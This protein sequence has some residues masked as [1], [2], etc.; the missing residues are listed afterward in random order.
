MEF[1]QGSTLSDVLSQGPMKLDSILDFAIQIAQA[2]EKAH[3]QNIV[4]RDIKP[5]NIMITGE[6]TVKVV[7]FGLAHI[8][9]QLDSQ[10]N[11]TAATID[12][13]FTESGQIVGTVHFL[14]PEQVKGKK[15]DARS[16]I[17]SF[18]IL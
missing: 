17:F 2:L 10:G 3:A 6:N 9:P 13:D 14:S 16:D 1:I 7:D 4:H 11:P 5:S 12:R 18:G 15:I 8:L